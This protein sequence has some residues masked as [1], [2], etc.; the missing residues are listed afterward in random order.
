MNGERKRILLAF[1]GSDQAINVA[2]YVG[3]IFPPEQ[4]E[5]VLFNVQSEIPKLYQD[6]E[7]N[8]LYRSKMPS[9]MDW[10][11][12][13]QNIVSQSM[14]NASKILVDAGFPADAVKIKI[15]TK[16][17]GVARDII[18]ETHRPWM[19][20][21]VETP[22]FPQDY[23][24]VVVGRKGI[25]KLKDFFVDSVGIRMVGKIKHIPLIVVG[26]A[27]VSKKILVAFNGS[28]EAM[29]GVAYIGSLLGASDCDVKISYVAKYILSKQEQ[30]KLED[31]IGPSI[32]EAKS[33]LVKSGFP[34]NRV[35]SEIMKVKTSR[36][37]GIIEDA[38][39]GGFETIVVG[40]RGLITFIEE[41]FLGRIS[42]KVLQMADNM[43]VWINY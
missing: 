14:E 2:H 6:L 4:T 20:L 37:A 34:S 19:H 1:D 24:A 11:A 3:A 33:L 16:K 25:S 13:Q 30:K 8:P 35:S 22:P 31:R 29:K 21:N 32:D 43:A 10:V 5:V 28:D 38:R 9:V 39:A 27:P 23:S 41:H 36:A 18:K 17:A 15:Q 40:R 7:V 26:G 12:E 42:K